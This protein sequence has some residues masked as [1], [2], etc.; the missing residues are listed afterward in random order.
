M[1]RS[2]SLRIK[3]HF[4]VQL[5]VMT[6][7]CMSH[8]LSLL[9]AKKQKSARRILWMYRHFH[10]ICIH[11]LEMY[12]K[13]LSLKSS[14]LF[15]SSLVIRCSRWVFE[16]DRIE[17]I[18]NSILFPNPILLHFTEFVPVWSHPT[19]TMIGVQVIS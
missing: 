17:C 8:F 12:H 10:F 15:C 18:K 7:F 4:G 9:T 3:I 13:C 5:R 6:G 19:A 14:C 11:I 16:L 1:K 2:L